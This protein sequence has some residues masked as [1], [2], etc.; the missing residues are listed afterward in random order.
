MLEKLLLVSLRPESNLYSSPDVLFSYAWFL[1]DGTKE[2]TT[3]L[4]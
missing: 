4:P 3:V 2:K 1:S